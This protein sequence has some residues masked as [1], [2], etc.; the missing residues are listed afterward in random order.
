VRKCRVDVEGIAEGL[1]IV[2]RIQARE[3][4]CEI[5]L[6]NASRVRFTPGQKVAL[7]AYQRHAQSAQTRT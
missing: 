2:Q 5:T 7:I 1:A 4:G 3:N 6:T